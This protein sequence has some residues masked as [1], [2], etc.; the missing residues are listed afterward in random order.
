MVPN[1]AKH[2]IKSSIVKIKTIKKPQTM[3]LYLVFRVKRMVSKLFF[4]IKSVRCFFMLTVLSIFYRQGASFVEQ[5]NEGHAF[6]EI[7]KY[8]VFLL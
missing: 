2:L 6:S 4:Q 7:N 1:G 5:W 8:A 3:L